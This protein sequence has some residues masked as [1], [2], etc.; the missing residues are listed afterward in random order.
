MDFYTAM[1]YRKLLRPL[2]FRLP[3]ETAHEFALRAL[4]W[5]PFP[6]PPKKETARWGALS[7]FGLDF[8]NPI[9]LAAGFDKNGIAVKPLAALG[10]GFLEVGTVTNLPQPGNDKPRLFRLP[11]DRALINRLGFNNHGAV[12]LAERLKRGKPSNCVIGVNIGKSRAVAVEDAIPDYLA[13]FQAVREVADYVT[14]NVSSP[15]TP[16]LRELQKPEAL[17]ELLQALQGASQRSKVEGQRSKAVPLL[18]KIAPDLAEGQLESIVKV[19]QTAGIAGLIATNTT[20]T[21]EGLLAA[22]ARARE[23]GAGG[24]SG[25][26]LFAL[27][28]RVLAK[29]YCLTGG[30]LPLIGVGGIFSAADAWAKIC[31][32][33][34]LLQVYTG[35]VYQG[36]GF[37]R[38]LN[39]GLAALLAQHGFNSLDEA[40]GCR[41]EELGG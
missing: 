9:G 6:A 17:R 18:L 21:R 39:E 37:A 15:N 1:L 3:P 7:R 27:S 36:P 4:A 2:L 11:Q 10:F 12:A 20:I 29:L 40:V 35:F 34:S 22:R 25:A 26:P 24:L 41:A 16:N 19:A 23:C 13:S 30:K 8:P 31:A 14:V 38:E 32:G 28:N 33:A 5:S